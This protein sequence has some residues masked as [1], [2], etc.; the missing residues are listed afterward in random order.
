MTLTELRYIVAVAQTRHFGRAAERCFISQPTLSVGI[1][2]LE[3]ELGIQVFERG[4]NEISLTPVGQRVVEQAQRVLEEAQHVRELAEQG[5]DPLSGPLRIG[6]IFTVAPYLLPS[7]V[8]LLKHS[9]ASMPLIIH[10]NYTQRLLESLRNGDL[11]CIILALPVEDSGLEI[12]ALYDEDFVVAV[13]SDHAWASRSSVPIEQLSDETVLLL[14][15]GNCFRDQVLAACPALSHPH[16]EQS[17][18]KTLE[19]SSL[20]TIRYMV[21]SGVG[22]TVLPA[23]AATQDTQLV[24]IPLTGAAA[25]FRRI[26]A[27]TRRSFSRLPA[28]QLIRSL[29]QNS[30]LPN[31]RPIDSIY[32]LKQVDYSIGSINPS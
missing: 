13:P 29:L 3:E 16:R 12:T 6:V 27:V 24:S 18:Q 4:A 23:T 1:K 11:D 8:P 25:P 7:L 32:L 19:G 17:W 26:A 31:T 30:P 9:T 20:S 5:K 15:S 10:E 2:K 28:V 21:A 14:S 22:I